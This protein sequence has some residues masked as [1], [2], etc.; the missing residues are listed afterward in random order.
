MILNKKYPASYLVFSLLFL[1]SANATISQP[2]KI[3]VK[4]DR[5]GLTLDVNGKDFFIKGMNWNYMPVGKTYTYSLWNQPDEIIKSALDS[6]MQMLE[7]IGVNAVRQYTGIP[8][9]WVKYIFE[10]YGIYTV[11]N[12]S[13]GRYGITLGGEYIQNTNFGDSTARQFLISESKS[14]VAEYK[15]TPGIL[16][17]HLGN[18]NN[19]GLFWEGAETADIPEG[20]TK[21]SVRARQL[22]SAFE[23][24]IVE[25]KKIDKNHPVA[26]CNG[27]LLFGDIIA[28]EVKSMDVLGVNSYSGKT[29]TDAFDIIKEKFSVR[30]M[31]RDFGSDA[32]DAIKLREGQKA[33]VEY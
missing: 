4:K 18:E 31:F 22:Y 1:I 8:P 11:L 3:Y 30:V 17:W 24:A 12:Y 19:Y 5:H 29:F 15:D 7:N 6:E 28:E 26:I 23:E 25:I 14:M 2:G 20:E 32:C 27:D 9:K 16:I 10:E 21:E 33:R 13:F